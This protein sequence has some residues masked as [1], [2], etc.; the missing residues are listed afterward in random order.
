[1]RIRLSPTGLYS[2]LLTEPR[3]ALSRPSGY[4]PPRGHIESLTGG[5]RSRA[6]QVALLRLPFDSVSRFQ[7]IPRPQVTLLR[8][9]FSASLFE[10]GACGPQT[11]KAKPYASLRAENAQAV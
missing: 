8:L 10:L 11:V 3:F 9:R 5:S 4:D 2:L 7:S 6:F 1:L